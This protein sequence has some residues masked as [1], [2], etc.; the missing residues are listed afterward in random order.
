VKYGWLVWRNLWRRRTR[1]LLTIL[2]VFVAFVL[3]GLLSAI[4]RAFNA[5][6]DIANVDRLVVINRISIIQP[7]PISYYER[8]RNLD[9][10]KDVTHADW[11]GGYYQ[12]PRNPFPQFPVDAASYLKVYPE[13]ELPP[14]QVRAW[15]GNRIGAI[16]GRTLAERYGWHLGDRVPIQATIYPQQGGN[17]TW[18]FEIE[19]IFTSSDP[20]ANDVVMLF[21]YDYFDEARQFAHGQVGWYILRVT[22]P[23]RAAEVAET[24]DAMFANSPAETKTSTERA[25]AESFAK[26]FGDIG[27]IVT[28]IL[29]AVFFTIL[30]VAGNTMAQSVRERI[31]ELAVLKTIGF[32]DGTVLA[33][34]LAEALLIVLIGGV[35]GLGLAALLIGGIARAFA[36]LLPGITLPADSILLGLMYM[37]LV[38]L[39]AG[40]LPA[41]EAWRLSI[42]QA[43]GRR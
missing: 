40:L 16:V 22:D 27:L 10:V 38:G 3:F 15:L 5:G 24:I 43:L 9:G 1:T 17:R 23:S 33:M 13:L 2:S 4:N 18:E 34:V 19:G 28:G 36:T 7:L 39:A 35:P 21:H 20:A 6:T 31:P 11:F 29:T 14:E 41:L 12:E 8:I 30:L 42:V 32:G 26:Q 37:V 25:F